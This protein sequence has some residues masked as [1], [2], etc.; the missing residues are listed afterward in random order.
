MLKNPFH[1]HLDYGDLSSRSCYLVLAE[2]SMEADMESL[3]NPNWGHH[4]PCKALYKTF[5]RL[6][7]I[8]SIGYQHL[9][10]AF[11]YN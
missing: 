11:T 1:T 3:R 9:S 7:L 4:C 6:N 8:V 10:I 5:G 2:R